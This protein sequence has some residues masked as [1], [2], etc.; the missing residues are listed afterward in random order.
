MEN[1]LRLNARQIGIDATVDSLRELLVDQFQLAREPSDIDSTDPLFSAGVGLSSM[2]GIELL[3]MLEKKYGV[4]FQDLDFWV[5]E[6]PT[7]DCVARYLVENSP[8][9]SASR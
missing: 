5:E 2:E 4:K 6:S 7:L 8:A 3:S 1:T 9:E